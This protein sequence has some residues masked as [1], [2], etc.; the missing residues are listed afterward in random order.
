MRFGSRGRG[1]GNSAWRLGEGEELGVVALS[2]SAAEG[3]G[4]IARVGLGA[5][6]AST[7]G[8]ASGE[9]AGDATG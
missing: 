6:S 5:G 9:A 8:D 2:A 1:G 3:L 4:A 7:V